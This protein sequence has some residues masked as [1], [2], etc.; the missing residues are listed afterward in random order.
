M[1]YEEERLAELQELYDIVLKTARRVT[2][3]LGHCIEHIPETDSMKTMYV[4]RHRY[5][6]KVFTDT[7]DYRTEIHCEIQRL[8]MKI[9]S[10][11]LEPPKPGEINVEREAPPF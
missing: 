5:F 11:E 7:R 9:R 3:D 4:E 1:S 6:S 2:R 8:E 10:L